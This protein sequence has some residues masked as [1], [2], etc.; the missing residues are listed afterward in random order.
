MEKHRR[1]YTLVLVPEPTTGGFSVLVPTLPGC[2]THGSSI[3]ECKARAEEAITVYIESLQ[4]HGEPVPEEVSPPQTVV[5][6]VAA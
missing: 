3:E 6:T 2:F 5:V 1:H 4:A